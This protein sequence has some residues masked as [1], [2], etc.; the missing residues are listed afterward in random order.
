MSRDGSGNYNLP[1][2]NPVSTGGTITSTWANTT[3]SDI[4]TALTQSIAVDG[5][6]AAAANLPM[7]NF[8]HTG[9]ADASA[10]TEYMAYGQ[11]IK[12]GATVYRTGS[13][14]LA[15]GATVDISWQAQTGDAVNSWTISYPTRLTVPSGYSKIRLTASLDELMDAASAGHIAFYFTKNGGTT[16][17]LGQPTLRMIATADMRYAGGVIMTPWIAASNPDYFVVKIK[18]STGQTQTFASDATARLRL[19]AYAEFLK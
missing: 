16:D 4:G 15:D 18:N 13:F 10:A 3:L 5:Q 12:R 17:F 11:M 6:T 7:N 9:V 19:W 8:K 1:A 2:G 14:T